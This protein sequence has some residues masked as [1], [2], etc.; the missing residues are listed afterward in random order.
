MSEY[1]IKAADWAIDYKGESLFKGC[2]PIVRCMDCRHLVISNG[3]FEC[4]SEQW[5][6]YAGLRCEV[7]PE[8]F[9]AWGERRCE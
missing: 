6:G 1:I 3:Y 2:E 7:E 9:C 4:G 8:G 5:E